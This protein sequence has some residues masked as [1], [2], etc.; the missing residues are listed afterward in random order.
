MPHD[1][2]DLTA[3]LD[4]VEALE[5]IKRLKARYWYSCDQ[6]DVE[7]VR[8]CFADGVVEIDYDGPASTLQHRDEL[9]DVFQELG[10][11]PNIV[12]VHHGSAPQIERV[13]ETHGTGVWG[14][15]YDLIDTE[16]KTMHRVGGYYH[17][18]YER[19][20]GAWKIRA[21]RFRVVSVVA[22]RYESEGDVKLLLAGNALPAPRQ[23]D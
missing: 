6:K 19:I 17:D 5:A 16:R 23:G 14:L 9:Y 21:T 13:D 2:S 1:S 4:R 10:C 3:L 8:A 20:D 11:K 18:R 7:A 22:L 12:E 15:V